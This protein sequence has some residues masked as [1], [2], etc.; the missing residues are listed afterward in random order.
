MICIKTTLL[1]SLLFIATHA[2]A[3]NYKIIK[4]HPHS[5]KSFTQGLILENGYLYESTGG[6]GQSFLLK[7]KFN[8]GKLIKSYKLPRRYFGEGITIIG[9]KIYQLT[10][11]SGTG[12]I[13]NKNTFKLL[14]TFKYHGQGWGLTSEG[15]ILIMSNGSATLLKLDPRTFRII[16]SIY[17]KAGKKY[18]TNLNELEYVDGI[19]Y[20]NLWKKNT[21]AIINAKN[22]NIKG[23]IDLSALKPKSSNATQV[24]NGIAYNKKNNTLL[25]T[26]KNW[27]HMFSILLGK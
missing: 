17:V 27:P 5:I 24:L 19:I 10:Y 14:R 26:G 20:A 15:R 25:V 2:T 11:R 6:Y 18:I 8:S 12:F 7:Y 13:Y 22:G 1:F 3:L 9:D 21:I 16:G 23:W 4:V